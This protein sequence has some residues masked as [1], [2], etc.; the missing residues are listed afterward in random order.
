MCSSW[1]ASISGQWSVCV[2]VKVTVTVDGS[3]YPKRLMSDLHLMSSSRL[4]VGGSEDTVG[5][6]SRVMRNNFYGT[7]DKVSLHC[8]A[9]QPLCQCSLTGVLE[10][11]HSFIYLL[12]MSAFLVIL[13]VWYTFLLLFFSS[14]HPHCCLQ[15][16]HLI[17]A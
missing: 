10:H 11:P 4:L 17:Q 15:S 12:I 3:N 1:C 14:S 7:I 2:C 5:L 16:F 9:L 8:S 6:T 13:L